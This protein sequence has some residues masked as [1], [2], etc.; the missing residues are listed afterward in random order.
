MAPCRCLQGKRWFACHWFYR[1]E[2]TTNVL[3]AKVVA[4]EKKVIM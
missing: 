2:D 3:D 1:P 4:A